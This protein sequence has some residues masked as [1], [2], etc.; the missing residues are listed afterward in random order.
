MAEGII[1]LEQV[2]SDERFIN[3]PADTKAGAVDRWF[4]GASEL[5]SGEEET[6]RLVATHDK[7]ARSLY[8]DAYTH[9]VA[10]ILPESLQGTENARAL[11]TQAHQIRSYGQAGQNL[12]ERIVP[13]RL[14]QLSE[15]EVNNLVI[16]GEDGGEMPHLLPSE[17]SRVDAL[18]AERGVEINWDRM[19]AG[20]AETRSRDIEAFKSK[21]SPAFG[22]LDRIEYLDRIRSMEKNPLVMSDEH[23]ELGSIHRLPSLPGHAPRY[24]VSLK[25]TLDNPVY[26]QRQFDAEPTAQQLSDFATEIVHEN[27]DKFSNDT[28]W[29]SDKASDRD[30][31]MALVGRSDYGITG[32]DKGWAAIPNFV[33]K[34]FDIGKSAVSR[35]ATNT[36]GGLAR[37]IT[38]EADIEKARANKEDGFLH[39]LGWNSSAGPIDRIGAGI[40][41]MTQAAQK[42]N[43]GTTED[44]RLNG[45]TPLDRS[46]GI[47]NE[48]KDGWHWDGSII[49]NKTSD[50]LA[51]IGALLYTGGGS[52]AARAALAEGGGTLATRAA[53]AS[54]TK[55]AASD[56]LL[57]WIGTQATA[58]GGNVAYESLQAQKARLDPLDPDYQKKLDHA[59][60]LAT[61][62]GVLT[63]AITFG[64]Q[65]LT[66]KLIT[67]N[68]LASEAIRKAVSSKLAGMA[69]QGGFRKVMAEGATNFAAAAPGDVVAFNVLGQVQ[70][71]STMFVSELA[72]GNNE[73]KPALEELKKHYGDTF[74]EGVIDDNVFALM[75]AGIFGN[76]SPRGLG[77][78]DAPPKA[79]SAPAAP[80]VEDVRYRPLETSEGKF[81]VDTGRAVV[82]FD[83]AHEAEAFGNTLK[84]LEDLHDQMFEAPEGNA[85]EGRK[86]KAGVTPEDVAQYKSMAEEVENILS[87]HERGGKAQEGVSMQTLS[88]HD[89]IVQAQK[90]MQ[91]L[92]AELTGKKT[93]GADRRERLTNTLLDKWVNQQQNWEAI[94]AK[95]LAE[96]PQLDGM[97]KALAALEAQ[98]KG[99]A[100]PLSP[101]F[102][103]L[104]RGIDSLTKKIDNRPPLTE[105]QTA[106]KAAKIDLWIEAQKTKARAQLT[107]R[108]SALVDPIVRPG[109]EGE[110]AILAPD[111]ANLF[112]IQKSERN[113]RTT[114][115]VV[116]RQPTDAAPVSTAQ[117]SAAVIEKGGEVRPRDYPKRE[118]F[119]PQQETLAL[120]APRPEN[121]FDA[122]VTRNQHINDV[123][124]RVGK[125]DWVSPDEM[126]QAAD[127]INAE[128]QRARQQLPPEEVAPLFDQ[129]HALNVELNRANAKQI[130][131]FGPAHTLVD[132]VVR[133]LPVSSVPEGFRPAKM[134]AKVVKARA[135][136]PIREV[137]ESAHG[138][139]SKA[140]VDKVLDDPTLPGV[141]LGRRP[142]KMRAK[143]AP[144]ETVP[145]TE[146]KPAPETQKPPFEQFVLDSLP[147]KARAA[148]TPED[149]AALKKLGEGDKTALD[150]LAPIKRRRAQDALLEYAPEKD[151]GKKAA[152]GVV[153]KVLS[154]ENGVT[155][156]E[157]GEETFWIDSGDISS[158]PGTRR[159]AD[160][161]PDENGGASRVA[162][163]M[164][165][166]R[167][168][169]MSPEGMSEVLNV[170][171]DD[172]R[173]FL[174]GK[175][176]IDTSEY[177]TK[178]INPDISGYRSSEKAGTIIFSELAKLAI[179]GIKKGWSFAQFAADATKRFGS[180]FFSAFREV[181]GKTARTVAERV[182]AEAPR[183]PIK[184]PQSTEI[185]ADLANLPP[186]MRDMLMRKRGM[187]P[188]SEQAARNVATEVQAAEALKANPGWK[189]NGK[190]VDA[191]RPIHRV[192]KGIHP[193]LQRAVLAWGQHRTIK[194]SQYEGLLKEAFD[195]FKKLSAKDGVEFTRLQR[196]GGD[197][198]NQWLQSKGL[199]EAYGKARAG[200]DRILSD[201]RSNG[202]QVGE[203]QDYFP[204]FVT[205][206][207]K[208]MGIL[209][210]HPDWSGLD[211]AITKAQ[212]RAGRDLTV[213]EKVEVANGY[214]ARVRPKGTK[215][216]FAKSRKLD[217]L[218]P[219]MAQLYGRP[220][221]ALG[222]YAHRMSELVSNTRFL[223]QD[224]KT[225]A[226]QFQQ[227]YGSE[228]PLGSY[229]GNKVLELRAKGELNGDQIRAF[230]N[231]VRDVVSMR[232]T[233][234]GVKALQS[235]NVLGAMS[236]ITGSLMQ[237]V[238]I[239]NLPT[240]YGLIPTVKGL[241]SRTITLKDLRLNHSSQRMLGDTYLH[242]LNNVA[243]KLGLRELTDRIAGNTSLSAWSHSMRQMSESQLTE[244]ARPW[245]DYL[246]QRPEDFAAA[247]KAGA[248]SHPDVQFMAFNA[249]SELRPTSFA[250]LPRT[251]INS[252][253]ARLMY[254][255]RTYALNQLDLI[256]DQFMTDM[257]SGNYAKGAAKTAFLVGAL[258]AAG[259]SAD[260]IRDW[261]LGRDRKWS[262]LVVDN[263]LKIGM[264]SQFQAD[265]I[266]H[267]KL[268][269]L[270][271]QF[272][273]T[274]LVQIAEVALRDYGR[275]SRGVDQGKSL[276]S[277]LGDA[278]IYEY[279]PVVGRYS[280]FRYFE[281]SNEKRLKLLQNDYS[282]D[283]KDKA[284]RYGVLKELG[285]AGRSKAGFD[286]EWGGLVQFM[287]LKQEAGA[288]MK[289]VLEGWG[290]M[291]LEQQSKALKQAVEIRD[292]VDIAAR[293][294]R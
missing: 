98:R 60:T 14:S 37:M 136:M 55:K 126:T 73:F 19:E 228:L 206:Y 79:P 114:Y 86:L 149:I 56:G 152:K 30:R 240:T 186:R 231:I 202:V 264:M 193:A 24:A 166:M 17:K 204:S 200:L 178:N 39:W 103:K 109:I 142:A 196:V 147:E 128:M 85:R 169:G 174:S 176:K 232:P 175:L 277:A 145:T 89:S 33:A 9:G 92:A 32:W 273:R 165:L 13:L 227:G 135:E 1:P 148:W 233:P 15:E 181:W 75:G 123:I 217:W 70:R 214:L 162:A 283:V 106:Q 275:V 180:K 190:I 241:T 10:S 187:I 213:E 59:S 279:F 129:L 278:R 2:L 63:G 115:D 270:M 84:H 224:V 294:T 71:A 157:V 197:E 23:G 111:E 5:A 116:F 276:L 245:A 251:Y 209:T 223:G 64:V 207:G 265:Q 97:K 107:E 113:G 69:A 161:P 29:F 20:D 44:M 189:M 221:E 225:W 289:K 256:R 105:A 117:A 68:S 8:A 266:R 179:A 43:A 133:S 248:W 151:Q 108:A 46:L 77:K 88:S 286:Q 118:K 124:E 194:H 31:A 94:R 93:T 250:G 182:D 53:L 171:P 205:D 212:D 164:E 90:E 244:H 216:S 81:A 146:S 120:P 58:H 82:R 132:T 201:A 292:T 284:S 271:L 215:P 21:V 258:G 199:T 91:R 247:I 48:G 102:D 76:I 141:I 282:E 268:G 28:E 230:S 125:G 192:A 62:E 280:Y 57:S 122:F 183:Q 127:A 16:R 291:S 66:G 41:G 45:G 156:V 293:K 220:H 249:L 50:I 177:Q 74:L 243:W 218:T 153:E 168:A 236:D 47:Q 12:A 22:H 158:E 67:E 49:A 198:F 130:A 26:A 288:K 160:I 7:V 51:H 239:A 72:R 18:A 163:Q 188:S 101:E 121:T 99:I 137:I 263:I 285:A 173:D 143:K 83:A 6:A 42:Q 226:K 274:P 290:S 131:E 238:E 234:W 140:I 254:G 80:Q 219:E 235:V 36:I 252:P 138:P 35:M 95:K 267:G 25:N 242:G 119:T 38:D 191:L 144:A 139:E 104:T 150:S 167:E 255:L 261:V 246:V 52:G 257:K 155:K 211:A 184:A 27:I 87:W 172:V 208:L 269:D 237:L 272:I 253:G 3:A 260:S 134:R 65:A 78:P 259:A 210:E 54:A 34:G 154:K 4:D 40:S 185:P 96:D 100:D 195:G 159:L 262:G 61:E 112:T 287:Q 203:I 281:G 110:T 229:L 170:H 11:L 222:A